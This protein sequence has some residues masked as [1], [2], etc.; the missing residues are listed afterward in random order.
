M[1]SWGR[2]TFGRLGT[3]KDGDELFPVPIALGDASSMKE[4][5][6]S[7]NGQ[8]GRPKF[9]GIATGAYHSLALEG[10]IS[11]SFHLVIP[12]N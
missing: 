1:Y 6:S 7:E 11:S 8:M 10:L 12:L 9:V 4:R 2:G 5:S 3:G